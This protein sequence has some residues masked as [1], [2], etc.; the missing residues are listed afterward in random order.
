MIHPVKK[1]FT[2]SEELNYIQNEWYNF[3]AIIEKVCNKNDFLVIFSN[4]V[5]YI[6][7]IYIINGFIE[8]VGTVQKCL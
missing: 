2:R 7:W 5:I 6:E 8:I 4:L 1:V 3:G